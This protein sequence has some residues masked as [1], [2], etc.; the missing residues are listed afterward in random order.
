[1]KDM[2]KKFLP[3]FQKVQTRM[4]NMSGKNQYYTS[5]EIRDSCV[6][7]LIGFYCAESSVHMNEVV[8]LY[9]FNTLRENLKYYRQFKERVKRKF[10]LVL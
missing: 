6:E 3:A 9:N 2:K 1:M 4:L 8:R 5:I 10:G 7:L